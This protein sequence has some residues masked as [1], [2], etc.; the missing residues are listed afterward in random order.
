MVKRTKKQRSSQRDKL[1]AH[2]DETIQLLPGYDPV[3]TA[4]KEHYFDYDAAQK[5]V[6]FF[7]NCLKFVEGEVAGQPFILEPWSQAIVGNLFGWKV[8]GAEVR[9]YREGLVLVGRKNNKT[10]LGAGIM[11]YTLCCDGEPRAQCYSMAAEKEQAS[12][13]FDIAKLMVEADPSL[14]SRCRVHD[15][16]AISL[17]T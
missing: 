2:W 3:A 1:V 4:R 15:R 14:D 11:L 5:V 16:R 10:T 12:F 17:A 7:A 6:D 13:A 9:R 8:K